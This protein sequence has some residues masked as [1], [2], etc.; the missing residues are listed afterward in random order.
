MMAA[1]LM[2]YR[3]PEDLAFPAPTGRYVVTFVAF[4]ERGFSAPSHRFLRSMLRYC[5]LE[6]HNLTPSGVLHIA[7]FVILCEAFLEVDLEF[8]LWNYCFPVR[9]PQDLDIGLTISKGT[10]IQ[11][12]FGH[13]VDPYFNIPVPKSMTGWQKKWFYLRN[14]ASAPLPAFTSSHPVPLPSWGG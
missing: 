2:A 8:N 3:E 5:S 1:E 11:V 7:A 4:Y 6:L 12:K 14:D 9:H 13:G 10:I